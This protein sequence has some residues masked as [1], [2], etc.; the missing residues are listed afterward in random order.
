MSA[1]AIDLRS[2]GENRYE[3][4]RLDFDAAYKKMMDSSRE[5]TAI[6]MNPS[7]GMSP[8]ERR[9]LKEAAACVYEEAHERFMAA[10][11]K[12]NEFMIA[13][14]IA[15]RSRLQPAAS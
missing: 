2:V 12:L 7:A 13:Q 14:S 10:V 5:F 8:E 4:L 15:S 9:E 3:T 6:L 1:S 11:A